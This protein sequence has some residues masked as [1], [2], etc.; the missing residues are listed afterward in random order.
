MSDASLGQSLMLLNSNEVQAKLGAAGGRAERLAK[1]PR[2]DA[3]EGRRTVLGRLRPRPRPA[4]RPP[5]ALAH[6]AKNAA[7]AQ[8][9]LRG[10]PL[11]PD[12]RQG[13][14]VQRLTGRTTAQLTGSTDR[15]ATKEPSDARTDRRAVPVL[16]RGQ[17]PEL[18]AGRASSASRAWACPTCSGPRPRRRRPGG[19]APRDLSVILVWL[20]GG[21]PQHE[22]YDPKPD[23]P[24]RVP[25]PAQADR[26]ERARASR[27]PSCCPSTPG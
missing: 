8:G 15:L 13:I 20:D 16:R 18:P 26:H 23:A 9:G 17:P 5:R 21:P 7:E 6:L 1:D 25:R 19:P 24:G 22:T 4:A 11:G 2:P 27:S 10:H 3:A 14:P 12:Q